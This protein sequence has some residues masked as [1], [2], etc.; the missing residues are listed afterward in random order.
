MNK[1]FNWIYGFFY[2]AI[3]LLERDQQMSR[4][5][6]FIPYWARALSPWEKT[7]LGIN[8]DYD[9]KIDPRSAIHHGYDGVSQSYYYSSYPTKGWKENYQGASRRYFKRRFH[10]CQRRSIRKLIEEEWK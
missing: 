4:T 10:H 9:V 1:W 2:V 7:S 3:S 5:K 6:R 8:P